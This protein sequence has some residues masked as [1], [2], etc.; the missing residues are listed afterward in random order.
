M[1]SVQV[2]DIARGVLVEKIERIPGKPWNYAETTCKCVKCGKTILT[3][4]YNFNHRTGG[5][6]C[7]CST[8]HVRHGMSRTRIYSIYAAIKDRTVLNTGNPD[9]IK[10]YINRGIG[11]CEEW[12]G[13]Y[14]FINFYE[15]SM[16]NG[17]ANNLSIDRID[18]DKGYSP[19]NC[20]WTNQH[21]QNCNRR[22]TLKATIGNK[23]KAIADWCIEYG[24]DYDLVYGR[25]RKGWNPERAITTP[26]DKARSHKKNF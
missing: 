18:N 2:G 20:R 5:C 17:Y 7:D 16:K 8:T 10:D 14:G 26:L 23:T 24:V 15:W 21:V 12:Q 3:P 13:K 11:L 1:S 22:N 25:I 9:Y 4:R 6:L 19:D